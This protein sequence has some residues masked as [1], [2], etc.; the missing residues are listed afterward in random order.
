MFT[1]R[2][3]SCSFFLFLK[4]L[5]HKYFSN[6]PAP[7]TG[8]QLPRPNCPAEALKEQQNPV[9]NLKRKR[10]DGKEQGNVTIISRTSSTVVPGFMSDP[11]CKYLG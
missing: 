4:A 8:S 6:R 11:D 9:P 7:T 1:F 2:T 3:V 10:T 5:K